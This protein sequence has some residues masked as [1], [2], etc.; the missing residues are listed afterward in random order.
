[1]HDMINEEKNPWQTLSSAVQYE[2]PWIK[3]EEHQVLNPSGKPGIY[4]T[5]H[6][7]NLAIGIIPLDEENN[8]WI[9]GQYRYPLR[10]YSWEIVEGGGKIGVDPQVSAARELLEETGIV[11]S[12]WEKICDMHLSN[13]VS[14]ELALIYVARGLQFTTA[15]PDETEQL[16]VKKIPFEEAFQMVMQGKITDSLSVAGILKLKLLLG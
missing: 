5:V 13:S 8:T 10:Q 7:K 1:M 11:A 15:I 2:N 6:F 4:G 9:V 14:D 12:Q 3:V 16:Q